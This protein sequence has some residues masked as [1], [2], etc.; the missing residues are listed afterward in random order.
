M[1]KEIRDDVLAKRI[2]GIR[3]DTLVA[4]GFLPLLAAKAEK[5]LF[6][7]WFHWY[8]GDFP[9]KLK[10]FLRKASLAGPGSGFPFSN[11]LVQGALGHFLERNLV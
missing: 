7:H 11:G 9:V 5:D 8:A 2:G 6:P 10:S 3:L 1:R 4:D